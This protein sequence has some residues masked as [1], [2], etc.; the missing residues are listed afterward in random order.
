MQSNKMNIQ[1]RK[2][3]SIFFFYLALALAVPFLN[4]DFGYWILDLIPCAAF[5]S[6]VFFYY[7]NNKGTIFLQWLLF[8][9]VLYLRYLL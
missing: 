5:I 8:A 9:F 7:R 1:A 4:A 2:S 3:W 6:T